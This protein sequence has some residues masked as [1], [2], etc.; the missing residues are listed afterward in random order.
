MGSRVPACV[1]TGVALFALLLPSATF[2]QS[3]E[4]A[5]PAHVVSLE[6]IVTIE[7][8]G[9]LESVTENMPIVAGDRVRTTSGRVEVLF[10]DG[11]ALDLDESSTL[12]FLSPTLLRLSAG[13]GLLTVAGSN[14]P[15]HAVRYQIDTPAAAA[16]TDGPGQYRVGG[17]A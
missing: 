9:T 6:G 8:D 13:R 4:S 2:A 16:Q 14:D 7:R 12:D 10:P 11:T 17:L 15:A 5:P 1:L 3:P